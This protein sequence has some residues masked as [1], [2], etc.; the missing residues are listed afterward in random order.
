MSNVIQSNIRDVVKDSNMM[1]SYNINLYRA[2]PNVYDGLKVLHRRVLYCAYNDTNLRYNK[3]KT[4]SSKLVGFTLSNYHAH[5]DS[6]VYMGMAKLVQDFYMNVPLLDGEGNWGS[7]SGDEPAA[8]RYTEIRT[9]RYGDEMV[10]D[11]HKST[12]N[13]IDNY[14]E[15]NKEPLTLPVKY[16]NLIIN[17][18]YGIG[19]AYISSIPP[20]NFNDVVDMT[21]K[22]INDPDITLEEVASS[23]RPDYP[24]GG[25]IINDSELT[26]AYSTGRG[27]VV[28]RGKVELDESNNRLIITSVPYMVSVASIKDALLEC[29]KNETIKGISTSRDGIIDETNKKNGVRLI[30]KAKKGYSLSKLEEDLYKFT[31]LQSKLLISMMCTENDDEFKRY[32]IK[33]LFT[34]WIDYRKITLKRMFN[35]DMAKLRR[36]IHIIDGILSALSDIDTITEISKTVSKREELVTK[37]LAVEK[38]N[39]TELQARY[40]ADLQLYKLG[41][42]KDFL[43]EKQDLETKIQDLIEYF[44]NPDKLNKYIIDELKEGKKKYGKDK[45]TVCRDIE[46]IEE[47]AIDDTDYTIFLTKTGYIKKLNLNIST[48]NR[49]GKGRS[50]GKLKKNDYIISGM[51]AN[52][53]DSLLYFTNTGRVFST[54]VHDIDECNLNALGYDIKSIIDL[55]DDERIINIININKEDKHPEYNIVFTTAKGLIKKSSLEYYDNIR[56]SGIIALKINEGDTLVSVNLSKSDEDEILLTSKFAKIARFNVSEVP[57]TQRGTIGVKGMDLLPDDVIVSSDIKNDSD[58]FVFVITNNGVGKKVLISEVSK[59]S[60]GVKG[61]M[62]AKLKTG[63]YISNTKL[64]NINNELTIISQSKMIKIKAEDV[65]TLLRAAQGFTIVKLDEDDNV[66]DTIVE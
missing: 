48:Q 40:I 52:N 23:I 36:R 57:L 35:N 45:I 20:H 15:D 22:L 27:D 8:M 34:K 16:P 4:K 66:L 51:I 6:S 41:S 11:I 25:V 19:K 54:N 32:N 7:I 47:E 28:V 26:S 14:L 21:I 12:V 17:G 44:T 58:V 2:F 64:I 5:G 38:Y 63:D 33:E 9:S 24:T 59:T 37:L 10:E 60:R 62:I 49:G 43:A 30:I 53:K 39:F 46:D 56:K 65:N 3:P 61:M 13:W 1:Y 31:P 29:I 55:K 42:A 50:C 18:G